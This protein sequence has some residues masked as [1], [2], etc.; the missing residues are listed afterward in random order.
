MIRPF[1]FPPVAAFV[2]LALFAGAV[3]AAA[4][5]FTVT[6]N[7]NT[8]PGSLRQ[9]I[10][11]ANLTVASDEIR[12][13]LPSGQHVITPATSL[14]AMTSPVDVNGTSQP[15]Y[16]SA[17]IVELNG[18]TAG[19]IGLRFLANSCS[20]RG[21]S[22]HGFESGISIEGNT[23][24][25]KANWIGLTAAGSGGAGNSESGLMLAGDF[26]VVGGTTAADR[27]VISG[28]GGEGLFLS[29]GAAN[30]A[31]YNNYIGLNPAGTEA[32]G[33]GA[34]GIRSLADE[35]NFGSAI[36]GTGNVISGNDRGV[37][38]E[39][40][41][42]AGSSMRGNI[43]GLNAAGT[44]KVPNNES[45]LELNSA[46]NQIGGPLAAERNVI[47]GNGGDGLVLSEGATNNAI[48]NT[49]IGLNAAG[50]AALGN[51]GY[52]IRSFADDND[53]GSAIAG[54]GNVISGN[55]RGVSL[56]STGLAGSS[57][58]GNIIGLNAAG[59]AKVPNNGSGLELGSANNEI[60]GPLAAERNVISGNGDD[61]LVLSEGATNNS[62]YNNYIG[63]NAAGTAALGNGG[64]GIRSFADDN[65]FGSAIAG[66]GNVIS[67]NERGVSLESTGLVGS[68]MRGN[69]IGLNAA[70]TAKVPNNGSGLEL[71]S[72]NNEIGGPLAAERNVISGNG[73]AGV[74]IDSGQTGNVVRGNSIGTNAAGDTAMGNAGAGVVIS[75][76]ENLVG[77]LAAGE[78]NVIS[79]NGGG[80]LHV[81]GSQNVVAGNRIGTN[82]AGTAAIA[83]VGSG[84]GLYG[85]ENVVGAAGAGN[86]ISGNSSGIAVVLATKATIQGNFI[87]T[88]AAGNAAIAN[89]GYAIR[90]I[91]ST[92]TLIGGEDAGEGNVMSGNVRGVGLDDDSSGTTMKGN[93]VGLAA[94]GQAAL[95]NL[96]TGVEV[97]GPANII[98][99]PAEGAANI[100]GS[101][102]SYGLLFAGPASTGNLVQGN[103]IG[104]AADGTT[105]RGNWY[106]MLFYGAS[107]NTIGGE[108]EG[109]GNLVA[110]ATNAGA[111]VWFGTHNDFQGNSFFSNGGLGLDLEPQG[112][113]PNDA[114]DA[115]T[116]SNE[117]QNTPVLASAIETGGNLEVEGTLEAWPST[118]YRVDVYSSPSCDASGFG[119]GKSYVGGFVVQTDSDG[120]ADL[121]TSLPFVS[122]DTAITAT[123]TSPAGDTSELSACMTAGDAANP[124]D[125]Q[126]SQDQYLGYEEAG[127][128]TVI[129]ARTGG[130]SG[131]VTVHYTTVESTATAPEDFTETSGTL[132][133]ADGEAVK[134]FQ[135][136]LVLDAPDGE[137]EIGLALSAPTGGAAL[138]SRSSAKILLFDYSQNLPGVYISDFHVL[139]GDSGTKQ[140]KFLVTLTPTDH[141]VTFQVRTTAGTAAPGTDYDDVE[142]DLSF[143]AGDAPKEVLV[144]VHGDVDEE[145][146]EVLFATVSGS[147]QPSGYAGNIGHGFILDDDGPQGPPFC[148]DSVAQAPE[149][150]DDG[151]RSWIA[152]DWCSAACFAYACGVPTKAGTATP[153]SSDALF[154]LKAAV[155]ASNCDLRV[156]DVNDSKTVTASD[157]L[158]ILKKAVGQPMVLDCPS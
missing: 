21:L 11:D 17:P 66:T 89:D 155:Q 90:V 57:M 14:P 114:L 91:T 55:D 158:M 5:V 138:G 149:G 8:G 110:G 156:C 153:R 92:E 39:S 20:V 64:Y 13:N 152:G 59:T 36:A 95:G 97:Y 123:A 107:G 52:G 88:N 26:G 115:D 93:I 151:D 108:G 74:T 122:A 23:S 1:R 70:G 78:G 94:D 54:T 137:Q 139:E 136:P 68:S 127:F 35:N 63:L 116:G 99:G 148:G 87:G 60:G 76:D 34:Y 105:L 102:S 83:N 109:E 69:I 31:I 33:N 58:R 27:N 9:A 84:V 144:P 120:F 147:I 146:T 104:V 128:A 19:G 113:L 121:A 117:Q 65:D 46:N 130:S 71:G 126:F 101:N 119:E 96:S 43:I 51:G 135:V 24:S 125:L 80:G 12:F 38:L 141:V 7:A 143:N 103:H 100:I 124:G 10:L 112:L 3:P 154:V 53:F 118:T 41:G 79:G 157:A 2:L 62:I 85:S 82:K 142:V 42:L 56:E 145:G 44:A 28:N 30:N 50:T 47:S 81:E 86:L 25:V 32:I 77:G 129:V 22:V 133:F 49:Y 40:T 132:T 75:G 6:T 106:N 98:G 4:A 37:S 45:G 67:G 18:A 15:G 134:S 140:A 131:A 73:G 16:A 29:A 150:C 48:E 61:G 72:S 111:Y